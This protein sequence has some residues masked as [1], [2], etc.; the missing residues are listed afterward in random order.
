MSGKRTFVWTTRHESPDHERYGNNERAELRERHSSER[1]HKYRRRG[2]SDTSAR[3][4]SSASNSRATSAV[5]MWPNAAPLDVR[6]LTRE[7]GK[8]RSLHELLSLQERHGDR[9]NSFNLSAFWSKFKKLPH[10][11]PGGLQSRLAPVCEQTVRMVPE[12]DARTVATVAHVFATS[13][14]TNPAD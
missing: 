8:A 4:M 11:E 3:P 9:F 7:L 2:R 14:W 5:A 13:C 10:E 6:A 1:E 12:L